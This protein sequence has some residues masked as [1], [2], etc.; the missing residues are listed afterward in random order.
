L[1]LLQQSACPKWQ[2]AG[3]PKYLEGNLPQFLCSPQSPHGKYYLNLNIFGK[4][5]INQSINQS[6][7]C[8]ATQHGI[9]SWIQ[10]VRA[11]CVSHSMVAL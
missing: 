11:T 6:I 8:Q 7:M 4:Q 1:A 3:E 9:N 10:N 2:V 5:T